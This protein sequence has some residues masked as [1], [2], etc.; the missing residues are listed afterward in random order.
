MAPKTA[1]EGL[2]QILSSWPKKETAAKSF[3][4]V[5]SESEEIRVG[6]DAS[7]VVHKNN[8]QWECTRM[9]YQCINKTNVL[10]KHMGN[11][12]LL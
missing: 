4:R 12:I 6:M 1:I 10:L 5:R 7:M 11:N 3:P 9:L 2:S 8:T